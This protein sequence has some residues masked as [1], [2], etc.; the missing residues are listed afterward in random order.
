MLMNKPGLGLARS[1][2]QANAEKERK[3]K[4]DKVGLLCSELSS[5]LVMQTQERFINTAF[6]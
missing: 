1:Y 2:L 4:T 3:E 6:E 5:C